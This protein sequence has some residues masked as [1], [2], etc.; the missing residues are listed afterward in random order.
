MHAHL[1]IMLHIHMHLSCFQEWT[2]IA[3]RFKFHR[4]HFGPKR[5]TI[6]IINLYDRRHEKRKTASFLSFFL[7][8]PAKVYVMTT[9]SA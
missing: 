1:L 8:A 6:V 7:A 4:F 5:Y 2:K 9:H 3:Y